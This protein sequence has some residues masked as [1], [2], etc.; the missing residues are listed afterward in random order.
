MA[1]VA[2]A[3]I[4]KDKEGQPLTPSQSAGSTRVGR[5][6]KAFSLS[7]G[8]TIARKL[9]TMLSGN[10]ERKR[11]SVQPGVSGLHGDS[12]KPSI[13]EDEREPPALAVPLKTDS[14]REPS[15][16]RIVER[17]EDKGEGS[18]SGGSP[19]DGA[20][21]HRRAHTVL[22]PRTQGRVKHERRGSSGS[23]GRMLGAQ[24]TR[25]RP[26]T[27]TNAGAVPKTAGP[28]VGRFPGTDDE[29]T[30]TAAEPMT[31]DGDDDRPGAG[32][33]SDSGKE[34]EVKPIYLK[35]LF[36]W[37]FEGRSNERG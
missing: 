21:M 11:G 28:E 24:W 6:E 13:N 29:A 30:T 23:M 31:S 4:E 14:I 20:N 12:S 26:R 34:S 7:P 5:A 10:R 17:D 19:A 37:I 25:A 15:M 32:E 36:R 2:A 35:G 18:P 16:E 1:A 22:D 33:S 9:G 3:A 8:G 27:A